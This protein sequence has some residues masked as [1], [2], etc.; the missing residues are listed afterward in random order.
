ML[1]YTASCCKTDGI[2]SAFFLFA[3]SHRGMETKGFGKNVSTAQHMSGIC[4]CFSFIVQII[5]A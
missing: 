5:K 4:V 3:D 2:V 1:C